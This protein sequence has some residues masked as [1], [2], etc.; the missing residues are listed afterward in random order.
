[1]PQSTTTIQRPS[2]VLVGSSVNAADAPGGRG[3]RDTKGTLDRPLSSRNM[4]F[5][6]ADARVD[7]AR[8]HHGWREFHRRCGEAGLY[9]DDIEAAGREYT[10]LAFR[11]Q[12]SGDAY[13]R[14]KVADGRG[15]G[16]IPAVL[17]AFE[18][19][20][21]A[22]WPVDPALAQLLQSDRPAPA[23]APANSDNDLNVLLGDPEPPASPAI[24]D[25]ELA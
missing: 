6:R 8:K 15:R 22:G 7:E 1:M 17:A 16:V 10:A 13:L 19:A 9:F 18:A 24:D 12:R 2:P 4:M 25:W 14:F 5:W 11:L 20:V 23:P 21:S 3:I